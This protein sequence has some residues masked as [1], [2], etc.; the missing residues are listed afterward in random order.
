MSKPQFPLDGQPHGRKVEM[1]SDRAFGVVFTVV[2]TVV[3]LLPLKDGADPAWWAAGVAGAFLLLTLIWPRG[4]R[5]FN[6]GWFLVG[7]LLHRVVSP[8]VMGM[9]F[10]VA[11]TP[12]ALA[13]RLAGKDPL[14]RKRD[15]GADS[16]WIRR[17]PPGPAP[18]TMRRQF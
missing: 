1:G 2:F 17:D 15:P 16:Y 7:L 5:P 8:L 14:H 10:F 9:L 3:A 11:V 12:V 6:Y 18:A 4:L 13:M